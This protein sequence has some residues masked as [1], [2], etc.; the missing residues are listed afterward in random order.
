MIAA[1]DGGAATA[2]LLQLSVGLAGSLGLALEVVH[3]D[4]GDPTPAQELARTCG[5]RTTVLEGAPV[6]TLLDVLA[7]ENVDIGVLGLRGSPGGRQPAGSTAFQVLQ[8]TT[9]PLVLVPPDARPWPPTGGGTSLLPVDGSPTSAASLQQL[10]ALLRRARMTI[11]LLHVFDPDHIPRFVDQ[12]QHALPAW[13]HEF[14]ARHGDDDL[15]LDLRVGHA[16]MAVLSCAGDLDVDLIGLACGR[17]IHDP[18]TSVVLSVL[19]HTS[20][21]VLVLPPGR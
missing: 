9:K 17:Q 4:E 10:L 12:P 2:P 21:P 11:H 18:G 1:I 3:V 7:A 20:V 14:I 13:T 15:H 8:E 5:V 16:D 6:P 19:A